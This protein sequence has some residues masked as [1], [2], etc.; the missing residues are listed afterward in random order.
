MRVSPWSRGK[1]VAFSVVFVIAS[2]IGAELRPL[3]EPSL[4]AVEETVRRQLEEGRA[5]LLELVASGAPRDAELGAAY[6]ALGRVYFAYEILDAAEVCLLNASELDPTDFRWH[7]LLGAIYTREGDSGR[8]LESLLAAAALRPTDVPT[9]LRLGRLFLDLARLEDAEA[10]FAGVQGRGGAAAEHGL[11]LIAQERGAWRVSLE[12]LGRA[13]EQQPGASSIHYLLGVAHRELG[14][15]GA[16]RRHFQ[17]NRHQPVIFEDPE[18]DALDAL[19]ESG[20]YYLRL[21]ELARG[22][23]SV[24]VAA[25]AFREAVAR[26]PEDPL[27]HYSLGL[28]LKETGRTAESLEHLREA[29]RLDPDYRDA[30]FNLGVLLAGAERLSEAQHHFA[31][32]LAIDPGDRAARLAWARALA[33]SGQEARA[34]TE[35]DA[36]LDVDRS[37]SQALLAL[38]EVYEIAGRASE[39]RER[40]L[41]VVSLPAEAGDAAR[42]HERLAGLAIGAG[43]GAAAIE[44]LRRALEL[45]PTLPG[46]SERLGT[47]LG[48]AGAFR[49]AAMAFEAAVRSEPTA[50]SPRFGLAMSLLLDERPAAARRSLEDGIVALAESLPLEHLLARVLAAASDGEVRDGERAERLAREVYRARPSADHAETVAMALA[51]NGRFDEALEWQE[52]ALSLAAAGPGRDLA[53]LRQRRELY[54][55]SRP[56]RSPWLA[57]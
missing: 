42:A 5:S 30:H 43:D 44:Q 39:A 48:Q 20:R 4:A 31:R 8:A 2:P 6:G 40:Y 11:G 12:H 41:E 53:P 50:L 19:V 29:V 51:E 26:A 45:E 13:L 35:L 49:E 17:L 10:R 37:D 54:A 27:G 47:L 16:A 55:G 24:D 56:C 3:P 57:R 33:W 15:L 25:Q 18:V 7:Y 14:D 9:Q 32:A 28:V 22:R 46:A 1:A 34:L 38:G 36:M 21:G 52:R 23:G